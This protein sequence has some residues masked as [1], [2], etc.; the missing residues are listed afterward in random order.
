MKRGISFFRVKNKYD[1]SIID[2]E[3]RA[4]KAQAIMDA[5]TLCGQFLL[6]YIFIALFSGAIAWAIVMWLSEPSLNGTY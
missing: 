4:Q 3:L 2:K 6:A 1:T 5:F